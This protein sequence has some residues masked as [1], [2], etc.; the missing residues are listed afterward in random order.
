M[1]VLVFAAISLAAFLA[2]PLLFTILRGNGDRRLSRREMNK[3]FEDLNDDVWILE[4]AASDRMEAGLQQ[5]LEEENIKNRQAAIEEHPSTY[6]EEDNNPFPV[7]T[8]MSYLARHVAKES[9]A[10]KKRRNNYS[11]EIDYDV[12]RRRFRRD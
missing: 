2:M 11:A 1:R 8:S 4:G 3:F 12:F 5:I 9:K 6:V 7:E 10:R